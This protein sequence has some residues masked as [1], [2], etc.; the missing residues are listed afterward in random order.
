M[1]GWVGGWVG[2]TKCVGEYA[3]RMGEWVCKS[4]LMINVDGSCA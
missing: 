2:E 1:G 3:R 4:M